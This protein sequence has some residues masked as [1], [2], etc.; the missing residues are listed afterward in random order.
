MT[1]RTVLTYDPTAGEYVQTVTDVT[2]GREA[3]LRRR[4]VK[5]V[6]PLGPT[7]AED[8]AAQSLVAFDPEVAPLMSRSPY[9]VRIQGGFPLVREAGHA[10]GPGSRCL[11][12]EVLELVPGEPYGRRLR[13]V[14]VDLQAVRVLSSDFDPGRRGQSRQSSRAGSVPAGTVPDPLMR[15]ATACALGALLGLLP[16]ALPEAHAQSPVSNLNGAATPANGTASPTGHIAWPVADPIWELDF[17]RP[18]N[19]TTP[20]GT[21]LEIRN[22]IYR[23][24][25][26]FER[27]SVPVLNVEY[28]AGGCG[29]YRDWQYQETP[30]I[31]TAT[32]GGTT[33]MF[34]TD[35][36]PGSVVTN[37]E[38]NN[39][40]PVADAGTFSGV[41]VEDYG[42]ELVLTG[43]MRAAGTATA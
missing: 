5:A 2:P 43:H 15:L 38:R 41:A 13:Y 34:Y 36:V 31:T 40:E 3:T 21:G 33:T 42:T 25:K 28:E 30:Y 11:Q 9:P 7:T 26:V 39:G 22:V 6:Y 1:L 16:E 18:A 20:Q 24:H 32:A 14:V 23:G 12:Y 27:A 8:A 10:C 37:C 19:R 35:A 17:Y 29:C 4:D